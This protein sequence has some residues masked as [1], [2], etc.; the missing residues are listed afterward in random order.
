[1]YTT[2]PFMV[3]EPCAKYGKP[4]SK[5]KSYGANTKIC[6]RPVTIEA[7]VCGLSEGVSGLLRVLQGCPGVQQVWSESL[8]PQDAELGEVEHEQS[9]A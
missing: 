3:I 6:Q 5:Q 9:K 2:H 4:M 1:M 7:G 8:C